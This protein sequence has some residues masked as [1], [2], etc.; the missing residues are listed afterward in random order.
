MSL[1]YLV[2]WILSLTFALLMTVISFSLECQSIMMG[3]DG[4]NPHC[5]LCKVEV[6]WCSICYI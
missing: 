4:E 5:G 1:R 3:L 2:P 6:I